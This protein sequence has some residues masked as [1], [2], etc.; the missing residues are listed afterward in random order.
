MQN[1]LEYSHAS[2]INI[3]TVY[4]YI[5]TKYTRDCKSHQNIKFFSQEK[6]TCLLHVIR[7]FVWVSQG[8]F[9]WI[10]NRLCNRNAASHFHI[11]VIKSITKTMFMKQFCFSLQVDLL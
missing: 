6:H 1:L 4:S 10:L 9:P 8:P 2:N 11:P 5:I 3:L 7:H